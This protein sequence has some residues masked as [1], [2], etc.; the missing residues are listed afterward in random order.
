MTIQDITNPW[1]KLSFNIINTPNWW[2][3]RPIKLQVTEAGTLKTLV[4]T[5][6]A[7]YTTPEIY[8][9]MQLLA[10]DE[11]S[12]YSVSYKSSKDEFTPV[13]DPARECIVRCVWTTSPEL[14][15]LWWSGWDGRGTFILPSSNS[16]PPCF[17]TM[18]WK[19]YVTIKVELLSGDPPLETFSYD[20]RY[21][22]YPLQSDML[23]RDYGLNIH[24]NGSDI[25]QPIDSNL[26]DVFLGIPPILL[27]NTSVKFIVSD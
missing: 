24:F 3:L 20:S 10:D 2:V 18:T 5:E 6:V 14:T 26:P 13:T 21:T 23:D 12:N 16:A 15:P 27:M 9:R 7:G 11:F 22:G 19:G 8:F 4:V 25:H 1:F 17:S